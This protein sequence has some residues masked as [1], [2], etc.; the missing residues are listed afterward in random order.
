MKTTF[1]FFSLFSCIL[2]F[3]SAY[4]SCPDQDSIVVKYFSEDGSFS[5]LNKSIRIDSFK[6]LTGRQVIFIK[7]FLDDGSITDTLISSYYK[8]KSKTLNS[9]GQLI[10]EYTEIGSVSG[11]INY[12]KKDI[13]YNSNSQVVTDVDQR[14]ISG[15]WEIIKQLTNTFD[16]AGLLT[17]SVMKDTLD[18]VLIDKHRETRG[19]NGSQLVSKLNEKSIAG[20]W[21]ND[22]LHCH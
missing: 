3:T 21:R 16:A 5:G 20:I 18:G 13:T 14:W 9:Q 22:N 1:N 15:A 6:V 10:Q 11:W 4:S 17:Q 12:S 2:F 8:K 7:E 19:Y